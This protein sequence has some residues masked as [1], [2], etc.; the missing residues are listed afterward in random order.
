MVVIFT[1]KLVKK[2]PKK[3]SIISFKRV[4]TLTFGLRWFETS[5]IWAEA[6][7]ISQR[8]FRCGRLLSFLRLQLYLPRGL[9][10]LI[11]FG[12]QILHT[13]TENQLSMLIW[14][15]FLGLVWDTYDLC[16]VFFIFFIVSMWSQYHRYG[17]LILSIVQVALLPRPMPSAHLHALQRMMRTFL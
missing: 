11:R 12:W 6:A 15:G 8:K 13:K 5:R 3:S 4:E 17:R 7:E 10:L 2:I 1:P 14:K 9:D 16:H